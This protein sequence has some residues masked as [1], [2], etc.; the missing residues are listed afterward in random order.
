VPSPFPS[1]DRTSVLSTFNCETDE[2]ITAVTTLC[3]LVGDKQIPLFCLGTFNYEPEEKEPSNGRLL[4]FTA[5][6]SSSNVQLSLV[7]SAD[8]KGCVYSLA[9]VNDAIVATVNSSVSS[10]LVTC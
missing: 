2:E 10:V 9:L 6:S 4:I 7:T 3:P 8:V 1:I 5:F